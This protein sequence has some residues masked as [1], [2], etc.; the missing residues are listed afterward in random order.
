MLTGGVAKYIVQLM[1]AGA[2][3]KASMLR[4]VT[5]ID[6]PFLSEGKELVISE[7]EKDYAR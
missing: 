6:S 3:N 1:D 2:T 7:F 4:W 5:E